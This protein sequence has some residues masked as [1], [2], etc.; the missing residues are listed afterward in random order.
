MKFNLIDIDNW[1]RKPYFEHFL[2]H[3]LKSKVILLLVSI[4]KN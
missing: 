3:D 4:K 2:N 1:D